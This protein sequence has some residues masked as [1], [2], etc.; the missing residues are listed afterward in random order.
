MQPNEVNVNGMDYGR[1]SEWDRLQNEG[2]KINMSNQ[3]WTEGND[4]RHEQWSVE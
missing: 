4:M 2:N 3:V 1:W